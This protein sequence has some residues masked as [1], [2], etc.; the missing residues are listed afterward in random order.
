[1][2]K[3]G[4][5]K[6][7]GYFLTAFNA[8]K[9]R[10]NEDVTKFIKIFNKLCNNLLAKIKPPQIAA[11]VVSIGAF[12][13]DYGL[14]L[15][16]RKS[17]TLDQIQTEFLEIEANFAST[18]KLKGKV[19]HSDRTKG[20]KGKEEVNFSSQVKDIQDQ[21]LD[22]MNKLIRNL[23]NKLVKL[24]LEKKTLLGTYNKVLIEISIPNIGDLHYNFYKERG[25]SIKTKYNLHCI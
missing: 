18:G 24:E 4:E 20:T 8:I 19:D 22:E 11:K 2:Q 17:L 16:Q 9:K 6:D 3:Q 21:K 12:E 1:M 14:T 15:R 7:N 5:K 25:K 10:P 13:L 23:S